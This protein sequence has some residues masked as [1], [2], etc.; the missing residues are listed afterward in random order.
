MRRESRGRESGQTLII[1]LIVLGVLL[2]L[3][4]VFLGIISRNI[5]TAG[6]IQ[7][8][9][10]ATDLAEAGIRYVHSQLL[11]SPQGADWRGQSTPALGGR[12]PDLEYLQAA[13]PDGLGEYFRVN[14]KGGRALVRVRYAPSDANIFQNNPQGAL[15][16]PGQ[17]RNYLMIESVGRPGQVVSNDPTTV[18]NVD[19]TE[20]RK[21]T[22]FASIGIIETGR[23]ITDKYNVSTPAEIGAPRELGVQTEGVQVQVP[24]QMGEPTPMYNFGSPPTLSVAPIPFGGS[25]HSNADILV[26][27][28]VRTNLNYTLGDSWSIA[29]DIR[30]VDDQAR[31]LVTRSAWNPTSGS[32]QSSV[33]QLQNLTSPSLDNRNAAFGTLQGVLKDGLAEID[34]QG[35]SRGVARKAPPSI[36]H[37]DSE[38]GLNRYVLLTRESGRFSGNGNDGRFG[39]GRGVYVDNFADRQMRIDEEGRAEA[40]TAEALFSDWLNPNNP[41]GSWKGPF[42]TPRGAYLQLLADGFVIVRDGRATGRQRSWRFPNGTDTNSSAIRY[43]IGGVGGVPYIINSYTPGGNI[44][45]LSPN[46]AAGV[47]FN[48]VLMFEGN[49]RVRGVIPTDLQLTVVSNA[50]VYVEGSITKGLPLDAAGNRINRLSRSMLM[51]AAKDYVAINTSQFFGPGIGD[52]DEVSEQA[53]AVS[54]NAVKMPLGG[55]TMTLRVEELLDPSTSAN[56]ALWRPFALDYREFTDPAPG[57]NSGP[58]IDQLLMIAHSMEDGAA[59]YTFLSLDVNPSL[60]TPTFL[61]PMS[62]SNAATG[63]PP[64][65][66]GYVT[67]GY[68]IPNYIPLY[69]LGAEPWQRFAKF[70]QIGFPVVRQA[71]ATVSSNTLVSNAPEGTY[72]L[73]LQDTSDFT[74]RP[75]NV[76]SGATNAWYLARAALIP[77]DVRIEASMFAEEG[78]V[79]VIPGPPFNPNPNDRRD[80]YDLAVAGYQ[81]Q[82]LSLGQAQAQANQDRLASYGAF[83]EMPFFGETPDVKVTIVGA[84]SENMPPPIS[85]QGEWLKKW[86]WIPRQL[87]STGRLI[88]KT[89]V[90]NG[91]DIRNTGADR[92]VPNLVVVYDPSLAT[93]RVGGFDNANAVIRTDSQ[94]RMLPPLPRLPVSPSLAFFGEVNP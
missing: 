4:I 81:S 27:G 56:P 69:G 72:R 6:R 51:L 60:T 17:A 94:G 63:Q 89:H 65:V 18:L 52:V 62:A 10:R 53:G 79:F 67:P 3:G 88:P 86:G 22:A 2:V 8:R 61:F 26:H 32:W 19:R 31:L 1:A 84:V 68:V 28:D 93:G 23:F 48:G 14:F 36:E 49:V 74:F 11:N 87:G 9:S 7:Q 57:M 80:G 77:H 44:N 43:R 73:L 66:P 25:L 39:H 55:G 76:G 59:P 78:S 16:S 24:V 41:N 30:G 13:G 33:T 42:Y 29:G 58:A 34:S 82:G 37:V 92:Y 70:E 64:Y 45:A 12:D 38:T 85:Q 40:G 75:N 54:W 46:Y 83:P 15:R 50:T 90:P 71:T 20:S 5:N 35:F 91:Y 21:M 47:P